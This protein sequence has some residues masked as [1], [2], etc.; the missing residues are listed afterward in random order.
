MRITVIEAARRL[1]I[2]P[3]EVARLLGGEDA[4]PADLLLG[5]AAVRRLAELAGVEHWWP[6]GSPAVDVEPR[7]EGLLRLLAA[8]ILAHLEPGGPGTRADN[9][10]RGLDRED[11]RVVRAALNRLIRRGWLESRWSRRGIVVALSEAG[12]AGLA[13]LARGEI[14]AA[15]F[16]SPSFRADAPGSDGNGASG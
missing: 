11:A 2:H 7:A 13:K 8:A 4:L 15:D 3:F 16:L 5:E 6:A 10:Y 12:A 14:P 1:G 9:L